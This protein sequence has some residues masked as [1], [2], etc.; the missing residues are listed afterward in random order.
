[1]DALLEGG[2]FVASDNQPSNHD[3]HQIGYVHIKEP[4]LKV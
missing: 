2:T 1:V 3:S 4:G